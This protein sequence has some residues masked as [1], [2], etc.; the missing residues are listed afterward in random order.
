[1]SDF[2]LYHT[3]RM[4]RALALAA[5]GTGF[6]EPNPPVGCVIYSSGGADAKLLGEGYHERYGEAHAEVN[7][8]AQA[9]EAARGGTLYVTLEPC[10]HY[11]KTP[12]CSKAVIEAGIEEVYVAMIDPYPEV[13][14]RGVEAMRKAGIEVHV[15]LCESEATQL[16]APFL[17]RVTKQQPWV[18]GKWAMTLDGKIATKTG[19]S[20]W[21]S[22][23]TSRDDVHLLRSRVDAIVTAIG[24]VLADDPL[25]TVR[26]SDELAEDSPQRVPRRVVL[27]DRL[28]IPLDS[29]LV[30]TAKEVPLF[31][32]SYLGTCQEKPEVVRALGKAGVRLMALAGNTREERWTQLL[33]ELNAR[34]VANVLVEGGP[35]LFGML[36][37]AKQLDEYWIYLAP[38]LAGGAEA[39]TPV[40]G[41]GCE[42]MTEA[43]QLNILDVEQLGCD[44]RIRAR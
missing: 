33:G 18:I 8:I 9:G 37:S 20:R 22:S 16:I 7:A 5:Q 27:D 35:G 19:H 4:N 15:G 6:V 23:Q 1:M 41:R 30:T 32:A 2:P 34:A 38:K 12:P 36:H 10:S 40:G 28:E 43:T 29:K 44:V 17:K 24:T 13:A 42:L 31:I 14:G 21:V 25:L 39:P 26:L 11:G 3:D